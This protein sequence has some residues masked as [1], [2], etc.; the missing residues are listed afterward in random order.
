MYTTR[1]CET[2][3]ERLV[4]AEDGSHERRLQHG[5]LIRLFTM[6]K[7]IAY[8]R[9]AI[10][11]RHEIFQNVSRAGSNLTAGRMRPAGRL[12]PTYALDNGYYERLLADMIYLFAPLL[13]PSLTT[14]VETVLSRIDFARCG[15]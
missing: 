10:D 11:I 12:L 2:L 4:F 1:L 9:P 7:V 14:P 5:Q 3:S 6:Y 8:P 13:P 15:H